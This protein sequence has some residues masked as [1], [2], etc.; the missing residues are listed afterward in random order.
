[1]HSIMSRLP[2][3]LQDTVCICA[4]QLS[5][6][7]ALKSLECGKPYMRTML[8]QLEREQQGVIHIDGYQGSGCG[9]VNVSKA[10]PA[11]CAQAAGS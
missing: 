10:L 3:L 7:V 8:K 6:H 5:Q 9:Q 11:H 4:T 1:M 2:L